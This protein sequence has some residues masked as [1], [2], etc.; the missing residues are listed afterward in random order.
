MTVAV[1]GAAAAAAA[2]DEGEPTVRNGGVAEC[3]RA[4]GRLRRALA[5]FC[6]T[7]Q[8]ADDA[9]PLP[10]STRRVRP[11]RCRPLNGARFSSSE[12][13][14]PPDSEFSR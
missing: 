1:S 14:W 4:L 12:H 10:A 8:G 2:S 13:R 5:W 11:D 7:G 9:R 3:G 6:R